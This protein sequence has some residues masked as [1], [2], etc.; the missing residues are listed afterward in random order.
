MTRS[1]ST[2]LRRLGAPRK[3]SQPAG[4]PRQRE[5]PSGNFPARPRMRRLPQRSF[6]SHPSDT[7]DKQTT[8]RHSHSFVPDSP[9][10][11]GANDV[12]AGIDMNATSND[13]PAGIDRA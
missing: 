9:I 2:D 8:S 6:S 4:P 11:P 13:V 12:L 3:P 7:R 10:E 5:P 1:N